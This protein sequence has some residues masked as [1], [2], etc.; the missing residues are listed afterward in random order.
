MASLQEVRMMTVR[1]HGWIIFI[2]AL[3]VTSSP[4]PAQ[5]TMRVA[6]PLFP[7]AAFPLLVAGDKGFFQK[8]GLTVEPI[9]IN[10]APTTYQALIS[11]DVHAAVG[12]P[13]GLL[14]SHAQGADVI[15]LGS[16]DN[17]VPYVWVTREKIADIRELRGKKVGV[18]RAGSK[19]WLIIHVLLQDAGLDPVKDL[20]LLQMGG[21]SQERVAALMRGGIDATLAD[22]LLEPV[23]KKRGF[24]ILRGKTTPFMNAP[25]AAKRSYVAGH[26]ST[27]KKFVKAFSDAT[28]YLVDNKEG[29]LRPLTQLLNS[30]DPEIT[31]FAYQYLHS[32]SVATLYPPDEAVKNLIRMSAH[33]DKKLASINPNRVVDL[34]ILDELGTKRSQ[35]VQK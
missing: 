7:T 22:A 2:L 18:N 28:R 21:G 19:P 5:E 35:R 24:F 30:N 34:S 33:M 12:A 10:S 1:L 32:N 13:T 20:T 8:E 15:S 29:T 16:W 17:L 9:R 31:D 14:P 25:I 26:R 4:S 27:L 3:A 11:G 23:M 6:I